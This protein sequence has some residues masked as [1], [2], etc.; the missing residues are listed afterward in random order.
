MNNEN[1]PSEVKVQ[2]KT[3]KWN[4]IFGIFF[5]LSGLGGIG[6]NLFYKVILIIVGLILLPP[7]SKKIKEK[8]NFIL[9]GKQEVFL[10]AIVLILLSFS[11]FNGNPGFTS[12]VNNQINNS[13]IQN[14]NKEVVKST[15]TKNVISEEEKQKAQKELDSVFSLAKQAGLVTSYE[16]SNKANVIYVGKIWYTQTVAFK[17]DFL[18]K[19]ATLKEKITGYHHF[20]V[21]DAYSNEK[22]AEVTAFSGSL[23]VYK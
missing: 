17:K 14:T 7:V 5:V 19:I 18:A 8:Y 16:F 20:Q 11:G 12:S 23:E 10:V 15:T 6:M 1:Q 21:L 9:S 3:S 4:W 22:V 13:N 2:P